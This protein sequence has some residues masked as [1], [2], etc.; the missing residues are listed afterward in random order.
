MS[1]RQN[2]KQRKGRNNANNRE[3][4]VTTLTEDPNTPFLVPTSSEEPAGATVMSSP[5][6]VASSAGNPNNVPPANY[7]VPGSFG[8]GYNNFVGPI[9]GNVHHPQHQQQQQQ[10]F[11]SSQQQQQTIQLPLGKNDLEILEK[12]KEMI[13]NG[14]H[15]AYKAIPQPAALASIYLGPHSQ[16]QVPHH[17]EQ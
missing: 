15:E 6:S 5:F 3:R 11:Y 13:K 7:Q 4:T 1:A 14:Q 2:K 9:H 10:P 12:L 8:Y 16:S 17:P